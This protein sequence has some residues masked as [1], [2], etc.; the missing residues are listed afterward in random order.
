MSE[1]H[2]PGIA[3]ETRETLV[4]LLRRALGIADLSGQGLAA[5][6]IQSALDIL[7]D[8]ADEIEAPETRN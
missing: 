2:R 5:I 6:H 7:H 4:A 3:E 8:G 1:L